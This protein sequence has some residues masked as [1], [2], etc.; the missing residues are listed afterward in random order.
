[1]MRPL[2]AFIMPRS[3]AL[4]NRNTEARFVLMTA[5]QSSLFMRSSRV[6]RVMPALLQRMLIAP[7]FASISPISASTEACLATSSTAPRP[8]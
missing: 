7:S 1:M 5:S 2:R 8:P 3:T 4:D 6:S